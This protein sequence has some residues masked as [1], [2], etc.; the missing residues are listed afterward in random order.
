VRIVGG[1]GVGS[2][3]NVCGCGC[4]FVDVCECVCVCVCVCVCACLSLLLFLL[5]LTPI[6]QIGAETQDSRDEIAH[7][8]KLRDLTRICTRE[9]GG[10]SATELARE[11]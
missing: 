2:H 1:G 5:L 10:R 7:Q 11:L 9:R 8:K 6:E 4:E 3:S